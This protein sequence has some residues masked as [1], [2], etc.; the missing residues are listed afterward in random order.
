MDDNLKELLAQK[1]TQL[2]EKQ[3]SGFF[4]SF[5]YFKKK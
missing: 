4:L 1:K 2:K 3:K 5:G